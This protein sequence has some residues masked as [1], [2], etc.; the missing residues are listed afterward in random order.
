VVIGKL[1]NQI[2][3]YNRKQ[4]NDFSILIRTK[5]EVVFK[6]IEKYLCNEIKLLY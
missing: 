6:G 2:L 1:N 5:R 4:L 3:G